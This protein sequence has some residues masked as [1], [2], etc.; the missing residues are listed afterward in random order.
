ME[1]T[2]TGL[3]GSIR[4]LHTEVDALFEYVSSQ[5][6][7]TYR[8]WAQR[9]FRWS[10]TPSARNLAANLAFRER[11]LRDLQDRLVPLSLSSLGRYEV[12]VLPTI[13]SVRPTLGALCGV[14][15]TG[16]PRPHPRDFAV[17]YWLLKRNTRAICGSANRNRP[18]I[19]VTLSSKAATDYAF[20]RRL[21][22]A[23]MDCA[24]INCAHDDAGDWSATASNVR[25]ESADVRR[26]YGYR[27]SESSYSRCRAGRS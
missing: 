22:E 21:V 3:L 27:R 11:D 13:A 9:I 7:E 20:V 15:D 12:Y 4:A 18:H 17:G 8:S 6:V 10:F 5:S 26:F 2:V 14:V 1:P 23:G 25:R 19:M 24:R 16:V